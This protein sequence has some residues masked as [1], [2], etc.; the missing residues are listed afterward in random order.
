MKHLLEE[1]FSSAAWRLLWRTFSRMCGL[2]RV[3][4]PWMRSV[5]LWGRWRRQWHVHGNSCDHYFYSSGS[6]PPRGSFAAALNSC[7]MLNRKALLKSG[8]YAPRIPTFFM[9]TNKT[10]P[11]FLLKRGV[12]LE[13]CSH[14][15]AHAERAATMAWAPSAP[16]W[17]STVSR[18]TQG[19]SESPG[20]GP[21]WEPSQTDSAGTE[22]ERGAPHMRAR[23]W[24]ERLHSWCSEDLCRCFWPEDKIDHPVHRDAD[25]PAD[26]RRRF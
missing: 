7:H 1:L 15:E 19:S 9:I 21:S 10:F 22:V 5:L 18:I 12:F 16:P 23:V 13:T 14:S 3:T 2:L 25:S 24:P 20:C 6:V 26:Q 17:G 8:G 4:A 11:S